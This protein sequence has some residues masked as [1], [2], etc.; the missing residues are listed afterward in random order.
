VAVPAH[1]SGRSGQIPGGAWPT[2]PGVLQAQGRSNGVFVPDILMSL[3][4][5]R[6]FNFLGGGR[7]EQTVRPGQDATRN[8]HRIAG[9]LDAS[10]RPS[11]APHLA[12]GML[13]AVPSRRLRAY[14]AWCVGGRTNVLSLG[15]GVCGRQG[16]GGRGWVA[17]RILRDGGW[18][19]RQ[20]SGTEC[21]GQGGVH[22]AGEPGG[23]AGGLGEASVSHARFRPAQAAEDIA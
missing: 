17:R 20:R 14:V 16:A 10:F 6:P 9:R 3:R 4:N 8:E 12:G 18:F 13:R 22:T 15:R 23:D 7:T 1:G 21:R 5:D 2:G 19:R 11:P